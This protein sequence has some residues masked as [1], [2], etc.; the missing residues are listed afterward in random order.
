VP[1]DAEEVVCNTVLPGVG[2]EGARSGTIGTQTG[3]KEVRESRTNMGEGRAL[4]QH[5]QLILHGRGGAA[6]AAAR[7][8]RTAVGGRQ[9][10]ISIDGKEV[11]TPQAVPH[12][13][14]VRAA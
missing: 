9:T 7:S 3:M 5:M 12:E 1:K 2:E 14:K 10:T 11:P 13:A 8:A 4:K 6:G